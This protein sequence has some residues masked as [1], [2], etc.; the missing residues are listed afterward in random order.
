MNTEAAAAAV[1]TYPIVTLGKTATE[2]NSK[3][4]IKISG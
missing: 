2:Y 4:G 1:G 3:T